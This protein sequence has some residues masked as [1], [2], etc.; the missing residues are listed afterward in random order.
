MR[1]DTDPA[2]A[3]DGA[4]CSA[5]SSFVKIETLGHLPQANRV[6]QEHPLIYGL[7]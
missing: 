2:I 5:L 3:W 7:N 4:T 1:S 6:E